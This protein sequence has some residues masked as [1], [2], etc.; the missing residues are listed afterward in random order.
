[1]PADYSDLTMLP[2]PEHLTLLFKHGKSTT[3]LSVLPSQ[4]FSE[5]KV[6]LLAALK[7]RN[8][9]TFPGTNTPLPED[10]NLIEIGVLR[11]R[12]DANKGW[13]RLVTKE[14]TSKSTKE[15]KQ[16]AGGK[17]GGTNETPAGAGLVD[18]SW[19]TYRTA[20]ILDDED[21]DMNIDAEDP[22]WNVVFPRYD[23]DEDFE[24]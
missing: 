7:S 23:D 22:G 8:I 17:T 1:M 13:V 20:T 14:Q 5:V 21:D 16:K 10:A 15:G 9:S 6:L 11:D 3:L 24:T 2:T 4:R 19:L 18:G 12:K